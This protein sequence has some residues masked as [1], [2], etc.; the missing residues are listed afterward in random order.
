MGGVS[1]VARHLL[2]TVVIGVAV[3]LMLGFFAFARP[4]YHPPNQGEEIKVPAELPSA[5]VASGAGWVWP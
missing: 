3:A 5:D 2:P 4:Q 1:F